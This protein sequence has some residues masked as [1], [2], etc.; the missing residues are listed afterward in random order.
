MSQG[1]VLLMMTFPWPWPCRRRTQ[2]VQR[3]P[4]TIF[5]E[6]NGSL[7]V[8]IASDDQTY[9]FESCPL[10]FAG[11]TST[12]VGVS[13]HLPHAVNMIVGKTIVLS[14]EDGS[15]VPAEAHIPS[16]VPND[17]RDSE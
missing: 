7:M 1:T 17:A 14:T 13:W 10:V 4:A 2:I 12:N 8:Q 15:L 9:T 6:P 11:Q 3:G 16:G 5:A